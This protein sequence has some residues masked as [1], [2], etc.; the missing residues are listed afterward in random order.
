MKQSL[1]F[2]PLKSKLICHPRKL[3]QIFELFSGILLS[4]RASPVSTPLEPCR[5]APYVSLP[6]SLRVSAATVQAMNTPPIVSSNPG[7]P[8]FTTSAPFPGFDSALLTVAAHQVD[9]I[10]IFIQTI[11]LTLFSF[12]MLPLCPVLLYQPVLQP[13]VLPLWL[14]CSH[15]L[16]TIPLIS[17]PWLRTRKTRVS[18]ICD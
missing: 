7:N 12:S 5:M 2:F 14:P 4:S 9:K 6:S 11:I 18:L 3:T 16:P 15:Y 10:R 1:Q 17:L 8:H 13:R